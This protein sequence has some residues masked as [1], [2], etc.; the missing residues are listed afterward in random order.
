MKRT[1]QPNV[2]TEGQQALDRYRYYLHH[3]QDLSA[4]TRRNYLSDL[5]QFAAW[6]EASWTE[7]Q[8]T[9][10]AF[11]PAV[12]TTS[13]LTQYR[14]YLQTVCKLQPATINRHLV[15]LKRYFAWA[16]E[17]GAIQRDPAK[18]VKLVPIV[19]QPPRHLTDQEENALVAAVTAYGT[20][21][22]RALLILMLHTGLR[23]EEVCTLQRSN[24]TLGK[25]SGQLAI[26]GKRNK[27]REVPLNGTARAVLGEYLPTLPS[28]AKWLFASNKQET[29]P[30]G[31]KQPTPLTERG[32]GYLV[33]KYARLAKVVDLSPHDLRHRFG[34]HMAQSV[35]LHRLAQ[36]MGHDS[37]DTTMI[38]VQGTKQDLQ[39]A[40]EAIA[41]H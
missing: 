16:A 38:Y 29:L 3:E 14:A 23:A 5:Q 9:A 35:P 31:S 36:I 25:R 40:V 11:A 15:S 20:L 7:G 24:I 33:V 39:Q 13:L 22:D 1:A 41:W 26:Y 30:D 2:S 17:R 27:Y 32:L 8:E 28:N 19:R 10:H 12:A 18:A 6:C 34:Y 37:L 21:R 4:D